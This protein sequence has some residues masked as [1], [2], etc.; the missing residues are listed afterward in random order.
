MYRKVEDFLE[1]WEV[2]STSTLNVLK[3][4]T[5]EKMTQS[6]ANDHNT[7]GWLGWHLVGVGATIG[8]F[9]G[10]E[11]PEPDHRVMPLDME[12]IIAGYEALAE[13]YKTEVVK[14]TDESLLEEVQ[15]FSGPIARGKLLRALITHQIHHVGQMTVLLRQADLKVPAVMGPTKEM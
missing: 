6:I 13:A 4:I 3:T 14:L 8:K 1:D 12:E 2:S 11:I 10:L 7:L 9:A 5:N 15:G